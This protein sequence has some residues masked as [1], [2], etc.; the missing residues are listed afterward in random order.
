MVMRIFFRCN[1][2]LKNTNALNCPY[3]EHLGGLQRQQGQR[4][5]TTSDSDWHH[6]KIIIVHKS[7]VS[8]YDRAIFNIFL[9]LKSPQ[10]PNLKALDQV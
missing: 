3:H 2:H 8:R 9:K 1:Y 5:Q 7:W 4:E 6:N 10:C